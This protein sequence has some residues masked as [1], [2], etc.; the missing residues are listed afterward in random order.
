M[1]QPDTAAIKSLKIRLLRCEMNLA[2]EQLRWNT[3]Q[4]NSSQQIN[5]G[6]R[7]FLFFSFFSSFKLSISI[8]GALQ[9]GGV[10][11][12]RPGCLTESTLHFT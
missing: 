3:L 11:C 7:F 2:T 6:K 12:S 1:L 9:G 10:G 5:M 4:R 8:L